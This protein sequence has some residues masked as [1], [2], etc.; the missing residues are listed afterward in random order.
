MQ[1]QIEA[2][3]KTNLKV[4]ELEPNFPVAYNNLAIAYMENG[5]FELAI[6]NADKAVEM[7]YDVAPEILKELATHR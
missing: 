7:G 2:C 6:E 3:I 5:E 4:I 1:G